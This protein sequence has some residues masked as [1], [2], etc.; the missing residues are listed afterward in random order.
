MAPTGS[1]KAR[2]TQLDLNHAILATE[3]NY[4]MARF[5][6]DWLWLANNGETTTLIQQSLVNGSRYDIAINDRIQRLEPTPVGMLA[7]SS[8]D[9]GE[10]LTWSLASNSSHRTLNTYKLIDRDFSDSRSH[11]FNFGTPLGDGLTLGFPVASQ[12][13][14]EP[15]SSLQFI[16]WEPSGFREL[17]LMPM[18]NLQH[19]DRDVD[20]YGNARI[21]FIGTRIMGLSGLR[22]SEFAL[23][24][25]QLQERS[26]V[27]LNY[28]ESLAALRRGLE[29]AHQFAIFL[30]LCNAKNT[31][32]QA[33]QALSASLDSAILEVRVA[34]D[35]QDVLQA[36]EQ[37]SREQSLAAIMLTGLDAV[38][39]DPA[40]ARALL[41]ALNLRRS[42]WPVILKMP[43]VFWVSH[44]SAHVLLNGAS[45]FFDWRS[46]TL[47]FPELTQ[48]ENKVFGVREWAWGADPHMTLPQRQA[49]VVELCQRIA[50]AGDDAPRTKAAW[51]DELGEHSKLMGEW[52]AVLRL[53]EEQL[54]IYEQL[55]VVRD[56]AITKGKIADILQGRGDLAG[57]LQIRREEELPVYEQLGDL[58]GVA[59]TKGKITD[60]LQARGDLEGALQTLRE[61][62]LPVLEKLGDVRL[63]GLAVFRLN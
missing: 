45:D 25:G 61:E 29:R 50:L 60:I 47:E 21:F 49:R 51:L 18:P 24:G 52:D 30:A 58:R 39:S 22:L 56:V 57:A 42:E 34:S 44:Q 37:A 7:I 8:N 35:T 48:V 32:E 15:A 1:F 46:D 16:H 12:N 4:D 38:L 17:G 5:Q 9:A 20:W 14:S 28:A 23:L 33:V 59:I 26:F 53:T 63:F 31:I 13:D 19:A 36:I 3:A 6:D 62:A 41:G 10:Y 43:V 40:R 55:G 54:R 11:A 2:P 27:H